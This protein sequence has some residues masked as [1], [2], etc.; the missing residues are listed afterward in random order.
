LNDFSTYGLH[1]LVLAALQ[2]RNFTQPTQIQEKAVPVMIAENRDMIA[3]APTGTGKTGAFGIPLVH[4]LRLQQD[5]A[6]MKRFPKAMILCPTREL[7]LQVAEQIESFIGDGKIKVTTLYGGTGYSDQIRALKS[8]VSIVVATPGRMKDHLDKGTLVLED[9][10]WLILD[11]ADE[12]LSMGFKEEIINLYQELLVDQTLEQKEFRTWLFSA[13]MGREVK[14]VVDQFL[15]NPFKVTADPKQVTSINVKQEFYF[16]REDE[17]LEAI[18]KIVDVNK[19]FYGI[20][21][22]QTKILTA[23]VAEALSLR[24]YQVDSL[25]GDKDQKAR[26]KTLDKFRKR[27]TKVL[28]CTDVAARG[29][30]ITDL[31]HVINYSL[32]L[33]TEY[34]VH[35]IGRTGRHDQS[36]VAISLITPSQ[37]R[38]LQRIEQMTTVRMEKKLLPSFEDIM[39]AKFADR[40]QELQAANSEKVLPMI[41]ADWKEY[42]DSLSKEEISAKFLTLLFK[43]YLALYEK[44]KARS[45]AR[46]AD[47]Y[48]R[49]HRDR[50]SGGGRSGG[51]RGN[52]EGR[53]RSGGGSRSYG[54]GGNGGGYSSSRSSGGGGGGQ[55]RSN[56]YMNNGS[57]GGASSSRRRYS[58]RA[59]EGGAPSRYI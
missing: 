37:V 58:D 41:S 6:P 42:L 21:F 28:V 3:L 39:K 17:K 20:I 34:Y 12:M 19:D 1:P 4:H 38:S 53:G 5:A 9:I 40:L 29:L 44:D 55:Y 46:E 24:G 13:T 51:Y 16:V 18:G 43:E 23:D 56:S 47:P 52:S 15:V 25:H 31:T 33:D 10:Q 54:G 11:E 2:K 57:G 59:P 50:D 22:C 36:G 45:K 27:E 49:D 26:E 30:D 35:R 48:Q 14:A 32:P 7:V 8:G